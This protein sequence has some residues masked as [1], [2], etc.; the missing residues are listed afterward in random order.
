MKTRH[1]EYTVYT[2]GRWGLEQA[3]AILGGM[4]F[5]NAEMTKEERRWARGLQYPLTPEPLMHMAGWSPDRY[6][7]M[8]WAVKDRDAKVMEFSRAQLQRVKLSRLPFRVTMKLYN[9][10]QIDLVRFYHTYEQAW[11]D[12]EDLTRRDADFDEVVSV[13][14]IEPEEFEKIRRGVR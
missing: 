12:A 3:A 13:K 5:N 7:P 1:G 9:D 14:W 2:K 4:I 11:K 6:T 8:I 10:E